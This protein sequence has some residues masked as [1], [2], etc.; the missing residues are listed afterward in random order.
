MN[1]NELRDEVYEC[2]VSH[3]WHEEELSNEHCLWLVITELAEATEADRL[4]RHADRTQFDNYMSMKERSDD[5]FAYAFKYNIKDSLQDELA[6]ACI[7]LLDLAG[8][9]GIS[10]D[11]V[12]FPI[13]VREQYIKAR[14]E[15]SFTEWSYDVARVIARYNKDNYPIGYLL[16][17]VLQEICCMAEIKGFDIL[18]H[19]Q[20]K[21]RYNKMRPYKHNKKY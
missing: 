8:V 14:K 21:V 11:S 19:I 20:Q 6:D 13:K 9:R 1:L 16:V 10:L 2:A 4:G 5:E 18:W 7:R 17:G 15:L 3:G 12:S